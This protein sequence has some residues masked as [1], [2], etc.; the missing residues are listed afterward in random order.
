MLWLAAMLVGVTFV[1]GGAGVWL[2]L[3]PQR[4]ALDRLEELTTDAEAGGPTLIDQSEVNPIA[5]TLSKVATPTDLAEVGALREKLIQAGFRG[6]SNVEAYSVTRLAG[7]V[8]PPVLY[9]LV[10]SDAQA[11]T[12][13]VVS[14][15]SGVEGAGRLG[16]IAWPMFYGLVFASI[17]YYAPS[18]YVS[19]RLANRQKELRRTFPDALDLICTSVEA[20]QGIDAA[21]RKVAAEMKTASPLLSSELMA[22]THEIQAGIPRVQALRNLARRTGVEEM[23]ALVN[24]LAQSERFGTPVARA[25]RVHSRMVRTK[26]MQKAEEAAAKISPYMTLAMIAFI[27]PCLIVILIG[28]AI[29][30]V[31]QILLPTITG[32]K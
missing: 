1:L 18:I 26:R 17:G 14:A 23:G 11:A 13:E 4:S 22:T 8:I 2:L 15:L 32:L 5:Q 9:A 25:L 29:V 24:V 16:R 7:T 10:S 31:R 19:N 27:L 28:P 21:F 12:A 6:R 20:G 30:N 3:N